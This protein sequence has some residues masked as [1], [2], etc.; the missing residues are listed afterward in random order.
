MQRMTIR[1]LVV[2]TTAITALTFAGSAPA[3]GA[4]TNADA[5]GLIKV[6]AAPIPFSLQTP[7]GEMVE[8]EDYLGEKAM[9]LTF[10]SFFCGPCREEIPLL[11]ELTKKYTDDGFEML[12]INLDGPKLDKAVRK[13]MGSNGYTFQVLWEEIEGINYK[14]ADAYGVVGTPSLVLIDKGGTIS[15]THVGR[16]EVP[17]MEAAIRKAVGLD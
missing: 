10:W 5:T 6:G 4:E 7:D 12:A 11:D 3:I 16:E 1:R 17:V 14:T 8:L 2:L 15:W 13:Y 9:L